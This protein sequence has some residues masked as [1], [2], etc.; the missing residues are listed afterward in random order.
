MFKRDLGGVDTRRKTRT[1]THLGAFRPILI[2]TILA[3]HV[4]IGRGAK[5]IGSAF[6]VSET[7]I[8]CVVPAA[9]EFVQAG[10]EFGFKSKDA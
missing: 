5:K 7:A 8:V 6:F 9:D 2:R 10:V 4:A 1:N 3:S